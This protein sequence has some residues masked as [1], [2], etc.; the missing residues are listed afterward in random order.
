VS[1]W[2]SLIIHL[3]PDDGGDA[4]RRELERQ[5]DR[6]GDA[7]VNLT[8]LLRATKRVGSLAALRKESWSAALE[9][10]DKLEGRARAFRVAAE[11]VATGEGRGSPEETFVSLAVNLEEA[12]LHFDDPAVS[13][14]MR[15]TLGEYLPML[16][17]RL[18]ATSSLMVEDFD[19]A[20]GLT[21]FWADS[22]EEADVFAAR[23]PWGRIYPGFL[24]GVLPGFFA[25]NPPPAGP[26][27]Q[28]YRNLPWPG[29]LRS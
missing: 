15:A 21:A 27:I 4:S 26:V 2:L 23:D 25:R 1:G 10:A 17:R 16:G 19:Y 7:V 8:P 28:R 20:G 9:L 3:S 6:L 24:F 12:S 5:L 13:G 14:A 11:V 29:G 18:I 22:P